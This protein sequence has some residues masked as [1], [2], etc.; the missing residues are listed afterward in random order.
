MQQQ[1]MTSTQKKYSLN[2]LGRYNWS[3]N[4]NTP[5]IGLPSGGI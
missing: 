1:Q 3:L 2:A 5:L 4:Y